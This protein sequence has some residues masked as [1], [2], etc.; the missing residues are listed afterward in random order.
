ML[1]SSTA[2]LIL[3]VVLIGCTS[4][5]S[6]TA[7]ATDS[8]APSASA[9]GSGDAPPPSEGRA[10]D[11]PGADHTWPEWEGHPAAGLALVGWTGPDDPVTQLFLVGADGTPTQ[12]TGV[13]GALGASHPAWSPDG[14]QLAF[15]D[16][17]LG[18]TSTDGMIGVVNADGSGERQLGD[19]QL[20]QW[21]PDG[22]RIAYHEVD[23]VTSDP[24]S[25]YVVDVASGE[26]TEIG[27]GF[28][29]RW[30]GP[31]R[32]VHNA[33]Q[34][35][36]DGSVI[37]VLRDVDLATGQSTDVAEEADAY[38]SPDGSMVLLVRDGEIILAQAG[39][40]EGRALANGGSP[41]WS[42]DGTMVAL[43]YDHD[44]DA[45]PIY[46]IVDLEGRTLASG[47]VGASP[48][49]SPDGSRL[50]LEVYRPDLPVVQ[51]VDL[52]SGEVVWEMEGQQPAWRP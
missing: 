27:F 35:N 8:A 47:I 32:I 26:I 20:P 7:P 25:M 45:N 2:A 44:N 3:A 10:S 43:N 36:A 34:Q 39:A 29:P 50:A 16:A 18:N 19:G 23:D 17:K 33:I 30:I 46:A 28:S 12:V 52:A 4:A 37:T 6:P 40:W 42:P 13:S 15:G 38:P 41:V 22:T 31:D 1:R 24:L 11:S 5:G 14:Q 49:W 9:S 48:T 51:V 21:S